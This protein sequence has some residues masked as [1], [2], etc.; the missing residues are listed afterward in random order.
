[1]YPLSATVLR[2]PVNIQMIDISMSQALIRSAQT[3]IFCPF[4]LI[5]FSLVSLFDQ[6]QV[7]NIHK[8]RVLV[9]F[10]K[11]PK[12]LN[13]VLRHSALVQRTCRRILG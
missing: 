1:M 7:I 3:W 13:I 2:I 12:S 10:V 6:T 9:G 5:G 4:F 11:A 8:F